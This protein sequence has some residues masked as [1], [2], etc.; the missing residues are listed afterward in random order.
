MDQETYAR[1]AEA[2]RPKLYRTAY[3]YLGSEAMA[4]DVLDEAVYKGLRGAGKLRQPEYFET[5]LTRILLNECS[6][7]LKRSHRPDLL[8][9]EHL[10][11]PGGPGQTGH[12]RR[13]I[14]GQGCFA[15]PGGPDHPGHRPAAL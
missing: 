10:F 15:R 8:C 7:E 2:L 9:R 5:W 3:C 12:Y 6:R 11:C 1:K 4:L 13:R 14:S